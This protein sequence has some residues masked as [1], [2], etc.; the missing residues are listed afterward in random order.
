MTAAAR[1]HAVDR[2]IDYRG[3]PLFAFG[4]AGRCMPA[5]WRLLESPVVIY[6]PLASVLS[7]L[8]AGDAAAP[9][10][11]RRARARVRARPG[12]RPMRFLPGSSTTPRMASPAPAAGPP[13][14]ASA[15]APTCAT[16]ASRTKSPPG[17]MPIRATG[18]TRVDPRDLRGRVRAAVQ[19][20]HRL[21][22]DVEVELAPDRHGRSA[23][24]R[25]RARA[26]RRP[27]RPQAAR[28]AR[29]NGSDVDTPVYSRR[30]GQG[31]PSGAPRSS[32]SARPPSSS[33]R[34]GARRSTRPDAHGASG[35]ATWTASSSRSSGA[36]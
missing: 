16:S 22:V 9:R 27:R 17:S 7:A 23:L 6:P 25:Q 31:Q 10:S 33:C 26:R 8:H 35:V 11:R 32:R 5:T 3:P 4:G 14:S 28:K 20:W 13:T 30:I 12:G 2:G 15:S 18:T 34:V 1:A 29:F 19:L 21:D 36:T 24:A